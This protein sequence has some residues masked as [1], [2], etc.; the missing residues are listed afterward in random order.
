VLIFI[1][2]NIYINWRFTDRTLFVSTPMRLVTNH[3][4]MTP[5][6]NNNSNNNINNNNSSSNNN[7][8]VNNDIDTNLH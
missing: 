1:L 4:K 2:R 5:N 7:N 6:N 8:N 3:N